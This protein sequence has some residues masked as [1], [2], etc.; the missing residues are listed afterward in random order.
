[1]VKPYKE[2]IHKNFIIRILDVNS[3]V[4]NFVWHR[5]KLNRIVIPVCGEDWKFQF[6]NEL[7]DNIEIFKEI[8]I[9]KNI[10]HRVIKGTTPLKIYIYETDKNL[11]SRLITKIKKI[12]KDAYNS[13]I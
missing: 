10:Y 5:D 11:D 7:P 2:T 13:N 1:M 6:D 9:Q 3:D 4:S 8:I 12:A